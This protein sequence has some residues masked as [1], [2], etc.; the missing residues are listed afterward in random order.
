[1]PK[2]ASSSVAM[3][4]DRSVGWNQMER[5]YRSPTTMMGTRSTVRTIWCSN[6]TAICISPIRRLDSQKPSTIQVKPRCKGSI[7]CPKMAQ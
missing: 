1:M 2:V 4:I 7:V 3:A 5:L 6:Q